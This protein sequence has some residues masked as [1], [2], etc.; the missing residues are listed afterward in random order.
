M[1]L[2]NHAP[3]VVT[4]S[5]VV[6]AVGAFYTLHGK[7]K[8]QASLFL[9]VGTIVDSLPPCSWRFPREI[10]RRRSWRSISP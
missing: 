6:A 2:H 7:H 4:G 9:K 8:E 1:F 5:F 10:S 3:A